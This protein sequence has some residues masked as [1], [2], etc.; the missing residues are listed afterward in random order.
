MEFLT[1][2]CRSINAN[3]RFVLLVLLLFRHF[4]RKIGC[5]ENVEGVQCWRIL[6]M[7]P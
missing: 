2:G 5:V 7:P 1:F 4:M 3:Y 6:S